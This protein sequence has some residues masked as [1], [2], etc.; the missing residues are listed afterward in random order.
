[1]VPGISGGEGGISTSTQDQSA[2]T[3]GNIGQSSADR[4]SKQFINIS[5]GGSSSLDLNSFLG[6]SSAGFYDIVRGEQKLESGAG[7][8]N[9]VKYVAIGAALIGVISVAFMMR[10]KK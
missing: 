1:M 9:T 7:Q 10:G 6:M 4:I 5:G 2:Q 3:S 8:S